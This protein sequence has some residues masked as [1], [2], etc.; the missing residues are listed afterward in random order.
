[1]WRFAEI[2]SPEGINC[3]VLRFFAEFLMRVAHVDPAQTEA[4]KL[5]TM[6]RAKSRKGHIKGAVARSNR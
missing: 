1:M 5:E 4:L 3:G 6:R 2:I